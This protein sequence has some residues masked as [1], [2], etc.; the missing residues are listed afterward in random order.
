MVKIYGMLWLAFFLFA[1]VLY[2]GG[3]LTLSAGVIFGF[4]AF[5]MVFMGMIGVL[6]ALVSHPS[7]VRSTPEKVKA[8]PATEPSP[9]GVSG[10]SVHA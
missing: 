6:P 5:G 2:A 1:A 9:R 10:H 8:A 4:V 7:P 3:L